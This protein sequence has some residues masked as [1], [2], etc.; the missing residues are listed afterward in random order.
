[1]VET[2]L[3]DE[4]ATEIETDSVITGLRD[5]HRGVAE[6]IW[7]RGTVL[8]CDRCGRRQTATVGQITTYLGRGWP[9]CHG[10]LMRIGDLAEN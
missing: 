6:T 2:E 3:F 1:M 8:R 5:Y 10:E 4:T 7:P 9:T